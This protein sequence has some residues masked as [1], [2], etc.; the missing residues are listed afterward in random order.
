MQ[1]NIRT[2]RNGDRNYPNFSRVHWVV[3]CLLVRTPLYKTWI[4]LTASRVCDCYPWMARGMNV[5]HKCMRAESKHQLTR[6]GGTPKGTSEPTA[7]Q[8]SLVELCRRQRPFLQNTISKNY[9]VAMLMPLSWDSVFGVLIE[10]VAST[11]QILLVML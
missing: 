10:P 2:R 9:Y 7:S 3:T 1:E 8:Q 4:K 11:T 5:T 6:H